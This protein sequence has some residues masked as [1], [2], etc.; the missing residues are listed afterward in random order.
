MQRLLQMTLHCLIIIAAGR[1]AGAGHVDKANRVS[2]RPQTEAAN[3]P[4]LS[5]IKL[6]NC[7]G[8]VSAASGLG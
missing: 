7:A 4:R 3:D 6:S 5:W 1:L 2:I 8:S